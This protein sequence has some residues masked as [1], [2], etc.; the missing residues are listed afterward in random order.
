M[1][2]HD[3]GHMLI[4]A[5]LYHYRVYHHSHNKVETTNNTKHY[6]YPLFGSYT[7]TCSNS[8]GY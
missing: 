6:T 3:H 2:V 5:W 1:F 4:P 8:T 7:C